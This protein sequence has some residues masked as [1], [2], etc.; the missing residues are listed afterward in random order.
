MHRTIIF[1]KTYKNI[2]AI[3]SYFKQ[4]LGEHMTEPP[5]SLNFVINRLVDIYTLS[6]HET[7][8]NK[9]SQLKKPSALHI[10]IATIAFG[11]GIDCPDVHHVFHWGVYRCRDIYARKWYGWERRST[12]MCYNTKEYCR[13]EQTIHNTTHDKLL[14][15][16][17]WYL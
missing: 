11:M 13:F 9:I 1:C 10:V 3:Y 5:G 8:K 12:V 17:V 6:T 16:E 14:Y 2:I 15:K 4:K 7:V